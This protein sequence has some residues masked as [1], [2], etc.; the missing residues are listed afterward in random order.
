MPCLQVK[1]FAGL[2][3][4][5]NGYSIHNFPTHHV[6]ELLGYLLLNQNK[7]CGRDNL[8][9]LLWPYE[10]SKNSRACL[11]T[12]L[13]RLRCL[14]RQMGYKAQSF[15]CSTRDY[16]IFAPREDLQFDVASFESHL[17]VAWTA[18]EDNIKLVELTKAID[19]YQGDLYT[20]IYC[21]WCL[22]ER[23]RL[24]RKYL[25]ALGELM[26]CHIRLQDYDKAIEFGQIILEIDP[27]R[28]E[29]HHALISCYGRLGYRAEAL[30]QFQLCTHYLMHEVQVLPMPDTVLTFQQ[31]MAGC[32][33]N[34]L[35]TQ[36]SE[37]LKPAHRAL[38][39]FQ[40]AGNELHKILSEI[41]RSKT[42]TSV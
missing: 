18:E 10:V 9:E 28:E 8:I 17:E 2:E 13:W 26:Y 24:A 31:A 22:L 20:G 23:E 37:L 27:L 4:C 42:F 14:F 25:Q 29:V 36:S 38:A 34:Y 41:D 35:D 6:E 11:N 15:L 1:G 39:Q 19:L 12:V 3:L 40:Q 5:G 33:N 16:I 21:D 7:A 32:A 30:A